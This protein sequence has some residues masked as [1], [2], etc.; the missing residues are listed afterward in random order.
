MTATSRSATPGALWGLDSDQTQEAI[1]QEL[2]DEKVKVSCIGQAGENQMLLACVMND[3]QRAA[4]R[5]GAGAVMGSKNL[6]AVAVRGTGKVP[7]ADEAARQAGGQERPRSDPATIRWS[8]SSPPTAL[9]VSSSIP[10]SPATPPTRTGP[11]ASGARAA[12]N[13]TAEPWP[14]PSWYRTRPVT[15]VSS[16]CA[17]W[18]KIERGPICAWKGPGPEYETLSASAPCS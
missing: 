13:S 1:R 15:V 12:R 18:I 2:G 3:E 6:K 9:P 16:G 10:G 8:R 11:R 7:V 14:R 17:R 5:G 4:G